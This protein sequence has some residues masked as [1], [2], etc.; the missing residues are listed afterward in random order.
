MGRREALRAVHFPKDGEELK[1]ARYRLAF[2][3]LYLIQCVAYTLYDS[4]H[5]RVQCLAISTAGQ[6]TNSFHSTT[7]PLSFSISLHT[8]SPIFML[9]A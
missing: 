5:G 8:H 6:H 4:A 2:S 7:P 3:E 1:R 9:Q